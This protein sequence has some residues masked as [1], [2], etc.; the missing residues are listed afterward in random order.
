MYFMEQKIVLNNSVVKNTFKNI[1][2]YLRKSIKI[3]T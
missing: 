2:K 3:P 1:L